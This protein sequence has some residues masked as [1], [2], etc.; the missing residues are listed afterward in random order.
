MVTG[1]AQKAQNMSASLVFSFWEHFS[2]NSV[3]TP[4][5]EYGSLTKCL[6]TSLNPC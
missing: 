3:C 4:Q 5:G 2:K 1:P 6:A